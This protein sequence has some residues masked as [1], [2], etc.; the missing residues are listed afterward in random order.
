MSELICKEEVYN[1]IGAAIEVHR[2][3][4]PG[5]LGPV[6]QEGMAVTAPTLES[7]LLL[8]RVLCG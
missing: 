5:F 3:L 4:G 6:Y 7:F 8:L 1:I 2:E